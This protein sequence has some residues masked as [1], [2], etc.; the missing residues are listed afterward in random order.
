MY[1]PRKRVN[2]DFG[3]NDL[4][5]FVISNGPQKLVK[6]A[7]RVED[8]LHGP[9]WNHPL[10]PRKRRGIFDYMLPKLGVLFPGITSSLL[11]P[12]GSLRFET[13]FF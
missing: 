2:D 9:T 5:Y 12:G 11:T 4:G 1:G 8:A 3:A 10:N 13:A 7:E 6:W